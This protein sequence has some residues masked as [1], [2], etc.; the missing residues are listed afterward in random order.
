[1]QECGE[2]NGSREEREGY[3][4]NLGNEILD[5]VPSDGA[6]GD[7][8]PPA[9]TIGREDVSMCM[10]VVGDGDFVVPEWGSDEA[11]TEGFARDARALPVVKQVLWAG[12]W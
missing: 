4:P 8:P 3:A 1:M 6:V 12:C 7:A 5:V 10:E 11:D 9:H 2:Q